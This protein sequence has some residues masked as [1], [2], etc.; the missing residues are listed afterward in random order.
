M[1]GGWLVRLLIAVLVVRAIWGFVASLI[2]GASGPAPVRPRK[3]TPLVRDPVCGTYIQQSRALAVRAGEKT[4]Y[5]CSED[6]RRA[7]T[8]PET[9]PGRAP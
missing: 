6:C 7:F 9:A 3:S 2:D 8:R 5:F 1:L 4:H